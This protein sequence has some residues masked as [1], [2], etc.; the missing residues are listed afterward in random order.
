MGDI[1]GFG[2]PEKLIREADNG[3]W[4]ENSW[5]VTQHG[6]DPW[7]FKESAVST[8]IASLT[9][10]ANAVS[11]PAEPQEGVENYDELKA[12]YDTAVALKARHT[13]AKNEFQAL[14]DSLVK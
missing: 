3:V 11:I 2:T 6:A 13:N 10:K 4:D 8:R 12:A 7:E 14:L 9:T 1:Y 5:T